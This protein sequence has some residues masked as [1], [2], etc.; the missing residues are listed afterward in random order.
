MDL[1]T[2]L[3]ETSHVPATEIRTW[4][5][6][7]EGHRR[8]LTPVRLTAAAA[9]AAA[10]LVIPAISLHSGSTPTASAAAAEV[11]HRAAV[12]AGAQPDG[13]WQDAKYWYSKSTYSRDGHT[14]TR[15]IWIGH[16]D[17]GFLKDAGVDDR[18]MPLGMPAL[19]DNGGHWDSLWSLPTD[20]D[21]LTSLFRSQIHKAGS[22]PDPDSELFT[23]VGDYL[24]ETPAPPKLRA[25]LY[26]V[27]AR[28]PGVELVGP[29]TDS[30]GRP[31][32]GITRGGELLIIDPQDGALLADDGG[33]GFT[34]TYLD[35]HPVETAPTP[36]SD[37]VVQS[38][39][40]VLDTR[41]GGH[42]P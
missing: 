14:F 32:I 38:D 10:V 17:Q 27:A 23:W 29:T 6:P 8:F 5:P 41:V 24:R 15:E 25:A 31:G 30:A 20:P 36:S 7:A 16:H 11:L 40:G 39:G 18:V 12:A 9:G 35:Q 37:F 19:F 26:E 13:G 22:G 4:T 3:H 28:V 21:Q 33:S 42:K 2:L 1:D 34:A